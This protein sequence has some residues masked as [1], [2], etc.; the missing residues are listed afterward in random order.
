MAGAS[1]LWIAF[2]ADVVAT[3][4][5]FAFS[6]GFRNS[7]F[8]DAY[9]SVAPIAI[10]VYWIA[11]AESIGVDPRR[12]TAVLLLILWWGLRLTWNW[13]RGW[14]GLDHEDWRYRRLEEQT[15]RA[16]WPVSFAGIHM[17]PT[18][19]V[20]LGLLPVY[21]ALSSGIRPWGWLDALATAV[22]AAAVLLEQ[23]ADRQLLRFRRAGPE[24]GAILAAG[25]WARSRHPNY[26][27]EIGFW[28]GLYLFGLAADPGAWWTV[29]GAVA[30]T[31]LFLGVS[32]PLMETRMLERRPGYAAH[33]ERVPL[34]LPRLRPPSR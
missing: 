18:L 5:I 32:L 2:A 33:R 11:D 26:L 30:I 34:L 29:V 12:Q 8:Y 21:A 20:F 10:G 3:G 17:L 23:T 13:A 15:G 28:W 1:P 31:L 14:S 25:L 9:W 16:W 19:L 22:T 4:V 27:G 7:S 24:P 6:V